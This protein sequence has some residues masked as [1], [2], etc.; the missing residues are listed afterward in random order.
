MGIYCRGD[1][2]KKLFKQSFS[3]EVTIGTDRRLE[4]YPAPHRSVVG[5]LHCNTS[6]TPI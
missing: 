2:L 6:N 5:L 1:N 3:A 4:E